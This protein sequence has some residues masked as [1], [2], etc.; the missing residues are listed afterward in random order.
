VAAHVALSLIFPCQSVTCQSVTGGDRR[1]IFF[2]KYRKFQQRGRRK[3]KFP[4]FMAKWCVKIVSAIAC[5]CLFPESVT[6]VGYFATI[7]L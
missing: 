2:D 3:K 5:R 7:N 6:A 1:L 4:A